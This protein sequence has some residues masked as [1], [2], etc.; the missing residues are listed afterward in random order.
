[1]GEGDPGRKHQTGMIR[2]LHWEGNI[3]NI[4]LRHATTNY[5]SPGGHKARPNWRWV[6]NR[7]PDERSPSARLCA[8]MGRD[9]RDLWPRMSPSRVKNAIWRIRRSP[10]SGEGGCGL[11]D[12]PLNLAPR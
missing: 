3:A 12:L 1:M 10:P 8:L 4:P 6:K 9:I 2:S 7:S 11:R 5:G